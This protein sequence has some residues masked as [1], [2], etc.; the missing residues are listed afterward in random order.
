MLAT[1]DIGSNTVRMLI[2][3]CVDGMLRPLHYERRITRLAGGLSPDAL[4]A[5]DAMDR[6]L[7][8]LT[9]FHRIMETHGAVCRRCVGTAALRKGSNRQDFIDRVFHKTRFI[10]DVIEGEEEAKLTAAGVLSVIKPVPQSALIFDI[11]GGSTELVWV[12]Q[13]QIRNQI[14]CPFGVVRLAEE[15]PDVETIQR[16]L[17]PALDDACAQLGLDSSFPEDLVLIGT[18]GT[19]T[20]LAAIDL[21]LSTY[22]ADRVNNH[23]ISMDRLDQL[24][25]RLAAMT[26]P[27]REA[28][29]GMEKGRGDLILPGIRTVTTLG[30]RLRQSR[31]KVSDAGLLEGAFLDAC[32]D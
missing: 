8:A 30:R 1:I 10:V 4:L 25:S 13:A 24:Y 29:I 16:F 14:S 32:H 26:L 12:H 11:G 15:Y 9:D 17:T 27:E 20:T 21:G 3:T 23:M 7:E 31:M 28:V 22:R 18:A 5:K 2:G 19:V 6:T